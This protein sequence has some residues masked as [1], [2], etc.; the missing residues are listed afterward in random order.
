VDCLPTRSTGPAAL[1]LLTTAGD[2]AFPASPFAADD[3]LL[4]SAARARP[5]ARGDVHEAATSG[6][7]IPRRETGG[8]FAQCLRSA[9]FN[10]IG[11][12]PFARS[13]DSMRS[14]R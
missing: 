2:K 11:A 12:R 1:V 9:A 3:T 4:W 14:P 6:L 10:G 13:R 8:A 7:R 5:V